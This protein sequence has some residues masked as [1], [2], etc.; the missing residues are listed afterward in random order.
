M[1]TIEFEKWLSSERLKHSSHDEEDDRQLV[2]NQFIRDYDKAIFSTALRRLSDKTQV[3]PLSHNDNIHTRLAHSLETASVGRTLG[4]AIGAIIAENE[5]YDK[6]IKSTKAIEV[7]DIVSAAC[8]MHD[9]GHP[10]FGHQGESAMR[11]WWESWSKDPANK[12]I[13]KNLTRAQS[14]DF[15]YFEGNATGFRI[16]REL[17]VTTAVY[18]AYM[19]Y[20]TFEINPSGGINQKKNGV[21]SGDWADYIRI[22]RLSGWEISSEAKSF[23][24][25]PL[26]Y[27][28]EASDDICFSV[29]DAED[30]VRLNVVSQEELH[31][32][33]QDIYNEE[34]KEREEYTS[35]TDNED[36]EDVLSK[37]DEDS[38][39]EGANTTI[40]PSKRKN[41]F[42]ETT[43]GKAPRTL[44]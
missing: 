34:M 13:V 7:G 29:M 26:A 25:S 2:R 27:L 19:K 3:F 9:I 40:T 20:P 32:A 36:E 21:Y 41:H 16:L 44:R 4:R 6:S 33:F 28:V 11:E 31:A 5:G 23:R 8:L 35:N 15:Q 17:N 10:P 43:R 24:R 22:L 39:T 38:F 12:C 30:A 14:K 37:L 42:E 1:Q 18:T